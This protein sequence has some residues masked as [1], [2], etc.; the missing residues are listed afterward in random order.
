MTVNLDFGQIKMQKES[1]EWTAFTCPEGHFE[2]LVMPFGLKNAP[3]IFQNKMDTIF[4]KHSD[5]CI[6]YIDDILVF[7]NNKQ[8]HRNHLQIVF[9]EFIN[10]GLIIS[11]KKMQLEKQEIEFLGLFIKGGKI[12]LQEHIVKKVLD[13]PDK[14]EEIKKLQ[15]FLGLLNYCRQFI[16][17]LSKLVGPLYSKLGKKW[18]KIF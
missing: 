6:V 13:F 3:Q 12:E 9:K 16:P 4:K 10:Q 15:A 2:W 14:L 8:E 18:T 17:N 1:I 11:S 7:S 5:F